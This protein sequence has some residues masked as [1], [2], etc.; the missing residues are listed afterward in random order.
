MNNT[1]RVVKRCN[2]WDMDVG[3]RCL[4]KGRIWVRCPDIIT[5]MPT[6]GR[7]GNAVLRPVD[8]MMERQLFLRGIDVDVVEAAAGGKGEE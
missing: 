4:H 2:V 1:E 7:V 6:L 5:R 3:Q 8:N